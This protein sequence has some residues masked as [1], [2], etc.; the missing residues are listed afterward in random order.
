MKCEDRV[1]VAADG[2][3]QSDSFRKWEPQLPQEDGQHRHHHCKLLFTEPFTLFPDLDWAL[4]GIT[5]G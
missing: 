1:N 3:C 2:R 4:L 5:V